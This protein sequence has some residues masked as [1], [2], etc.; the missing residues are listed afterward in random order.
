MRLERFIFTLIYGSYQAKHK[1]RL[2]YVLDPFVPI[3]QHQQYQAIINLL[4]Y[5]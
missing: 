2:N 5:V 1:S 4:S 3:T